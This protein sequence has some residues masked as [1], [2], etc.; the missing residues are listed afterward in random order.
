LWATK[1]FTNKYVTCL[2]RLAEPV[3][4]DIY[5]EKYAKWRREDMPIL[6][7]NRRFTNIAKLDKHMA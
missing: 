1:L 4:A 6:P 3:S 2:D 5:D 7:E